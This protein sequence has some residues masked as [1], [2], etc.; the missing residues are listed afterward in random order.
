METKTIKNYFTDTIA[1]LVLVSSK[2]KTTRRDL[3]DVLRILSQ[4]SVHDVLFPNSSSKKLDKKLDKKRVESFIKFYKKG[5]TGNTNHLFLL[6][7]KEGVVGG[8]DLQIVDANNASLGFWQDS[9]QKGFMTNAV[10]E[11]MS[12][13]LKKKLEVLDAYVD[14]D[15][16]K[17]IN[18]LNRSGFSYKGIVKGKTR[19]LKKFMIVL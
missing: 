5:N 1:N 9:N 13:A 14:L 7:T 15:N 16:D 17:A 6:K 3:A 11:I 18:L 10:N 12:V 19:K 8:V 2:N 4:S